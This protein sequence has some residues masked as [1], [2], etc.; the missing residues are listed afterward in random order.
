MVA[1][2][3]IQL[4]GSKSSLA[5]NKRRLRSCAP[6]HQP[7]PTPINTQ[8]ARTPHTGALLWGLV[9][10][11]AVT[12]LLAVP[13]LALPLAPKELALGLAVFCCVPTALSSGITYT[14]VRVCVHVGPAC[15]CVLPH[16]LVR[17]TDCV[18]G[19]TQ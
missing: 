18:H 17:C 7:P 6:V 13:V 16:K 9:S 5:N 2:R 3:G 14:Q 8:T 11:L 10:I 15:V 12:P 19:G 1:P 4:H